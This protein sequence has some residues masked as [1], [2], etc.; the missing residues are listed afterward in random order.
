[1]EIGEAVRVVEAHEVI[2]LYISRKVWRHAACLEF[3]EEEQWELRTR[4][5]G[6]TVH[7]RWVLT[8]STEA[9]RVTRSIQVE[10]HV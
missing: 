10:A 3:W 7:S 5:S 9:Q 1:M 6:K 8:V 4:H 2:V